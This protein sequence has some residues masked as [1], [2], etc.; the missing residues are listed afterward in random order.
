MSYP[1]KLLRLNPARGIASDTPAHMLGPDFYSTGRNVHFRKGIAGR[2]GGSREVYGTLPVDVMH[3]RN[4]RVGQTNFW[5]VFGADEVHAL[6]T[7]NSDDVTPIAGLQ[8]IVQ[9]W[10]YASTLLN[11]VPVFTNGLDAPQFWPGTVVDPFEE[12]PDWPAATICKSIAAF[13]YHLFALDIDGPAGHFESQILWSDAAEP[14]TVPALWTPAADNEAG[15]AELGDTP[16]PV[17]QGVLLRGSL[18]LYKRSS[19]YAVDYVGGNEV[20]SVRPLF[21]SSGALTR[22]AAC[23]INGQH[24]VVTDGDIILTDGTSRRSVGQARMREFLFAQ[25]DQDN[26]EN[27]FTVLH[28]GKGEVWT[29]FPETGHQYCTKALV[30]DIANDA[31]GVRDLDDVTCAEIGIV[32]DTAP[33]ESW[34]ADAQAWDDDN[35]YWNQANYSL[36][37]ESLVLGFDDVA[38]MQDTD[39]NVTRDASIGRYDLTFGES[40]RVK[41]LRSIHVRSQ[42]GAGSL[43]VRAGGRM[44]PTDTIQWSAERELVEPDQRVN[45]HVRGRYISVEVRSEGDDAWT[46]AGLDLE[47]EMRGYF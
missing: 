14:G 8:S 24:F 41:F 38:E 27:V 3:L 46:I 7:S 16:G 40:E 15:D 31:L 32:N 28:R 47:A 35:S 19:T 4:A 10:Q 30:Y 36:A 39:D 5:L 34:D 11:G 13:K 2:A 1:K 12:L 44:S 9:P 21:S 25:L 18:L 43:Y 22:H 26:Y 23:D 17:F 42:P 20:F 37:V 33:D 6:E 45:M 29:C